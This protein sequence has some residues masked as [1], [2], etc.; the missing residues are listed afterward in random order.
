MNF[1][2]DN[3]STNQTNTRILGFTDTIVF[4]TDT[5][6][7][8]KGLNTLSLTSNIITSNFDLTCY[9][10][11]K[12][13]NNFLS[14]IYITSNLLYYYGY[15]VSRPYPPKT[16]TSSSSQS[17]ITY[18]TQ[19]PTYYETITLNTTDITYGSG[20]YEIYSSSID[21]TIVNFSGT[22]STLNTVSGNTD[23]AYV[24]FPNSGTFTINN[25]LICDILIVGGGGGG[26]SGNSTSWEGG[27]GGAGG[28]V[29][30]VNKQLNTGTYKIVVGSGGA[31]NTNGSDSKITDNSDIILQLIVLVLLEK[32]EEKVHQVEVLVV[33]VDQVVEEHIQ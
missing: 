4:N 25:N 24:M 9:G 5:N 22:G 16:Y 17:V 12:E 33:M 28:V 8:N 2:I 7:Y 3:T 18:L 23:Y 26:G 21:D 30:M 19:N 10:Q 27:G 15:S 29:Y 20:T 1:P 31:A 13:N 32:E 11:I 6:F 14:N